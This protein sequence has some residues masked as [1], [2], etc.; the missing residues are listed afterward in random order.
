MSEISYL[1]AR[2]EA[3]RI[4][5]GHNKNRNNIFRLYPIVIY[6]S[7][8]DAQQGE[9]LIQAEEVALKVPPGQSERDIVVY[10]I[11]G[12]S[13]ANEIQRYLRVE[14]GGYLPKAVGGI[15]F[16]R[17]NVLILTNGQELPLKGQNL[18]PP[19]Q[20]KSIND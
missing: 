2:H 5:Q 13:A 8:T 14:R 18:P 11:R 7:L 4:K 16:Q 19:P 12:A 1:N 10:F 9:N 17:E 3:I 6:P 15:I 20:N